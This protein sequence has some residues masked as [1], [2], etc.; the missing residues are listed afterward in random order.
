MPTVVKYLPFPDF[1]W[2][3]GGQ[4]AEQGQ[5]TKLKKMARKYPNTSYLIEPMFQQRYIQL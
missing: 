2:G 3:G 1:F 5:I 4:R